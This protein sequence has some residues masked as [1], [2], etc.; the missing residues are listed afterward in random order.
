MTKILLNIYIGDL[1]ITRRIFESLKQDLDREKE[2]I[3]LEGNKIIYIIEDENFSHILAA[4]SSFLKL[5]N[6]ALKL[7]DSLRE[8]TLK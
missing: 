8:K 4:T 7:E 1:D 3:E 6:E 2:K 5:I